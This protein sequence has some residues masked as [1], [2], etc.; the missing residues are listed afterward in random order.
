VD[1]RPSTG[2]LRAG[3]ALTASADEIEHAIY[4]LREDARMW[5][6][7]ANADGEK[8][9]GG[10]QDLH[11]HL[12]FV[13]VRDLTMGLRRILDRGR[14]DKADVPQEPDLVSL[15]R[16][17]ED[18]GK[19]AEGDRLRKLPAF[20]HLLTIADKSIAH[21]NTA[22][23]RAISVGASGVPGLAAHLSQPRL[24]F[25]MVDAVSRSYD[26][27]VRAVDFEATY[28]YRDRLDDPFRR[29]VQ[30]AGVP[31]VDFHLTDVFLDPSLLAPSLRR[32]PPDLTNDQVIAYVTHCVRCAEKEGSG[33]PVAAEMGHVATHYRGRAE[34]ILG[35]VS[36]SRRSKL[37]AR[38]KA[39]G[40]KLFATAPKPPLILS[41][42]GATF[43]VV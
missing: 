12:S 9:F 10:S 11:E 21:G 7:V 39:A 2:Y 41:T 43:R 20:R 6:A 32:G 28:L 33:H 24:L 34:Q 38:L 27:N 36:S 29:H 37:E 14:R 19:Q 30:R 13:A 35:S 31:W 3:C 17:L 8:W 40:V 16:L 42:P 22:A 15:Y 23:L 18:N 5:N 26:A 4:E 25:T 1:P